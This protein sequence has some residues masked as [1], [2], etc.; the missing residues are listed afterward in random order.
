M[1]VFEEGS[2]ELLS[3]SLG[4]QESY[5]G[6][7]G[8]LEDMQRRGLSEPLLIVIDGCPGL[9][10]A[11]K[12]VFSSSDI[13]RCTKH[14]TEN[15]LNKVLKEDRD[16]VRDSLREIFYASTYDHAME[17]VELFKRKRGKRY[18]RAVECLLED[19]EAC[20]TYYKYPYQHWRRIRTTNVVERSFGEVKRRTKGI[21]RFKDEQRALMMVYWQLKGLRCNGIGMT[22]EARMI[23]ADIKA[24]KIQRIAA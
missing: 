2:R 20:L 6:W 4:N 8:F 7:K 13:Q 14:K 16:K 21:G 9:I 19:R 3:I 17:A 24:S 10:K 15:V 11:V 1:G 23:L 5:N 22:K 12:G 18:P